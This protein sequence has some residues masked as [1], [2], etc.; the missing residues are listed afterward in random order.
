MIKRILVPLDGSELAEGVLP[1][2]ADLAKGLQAEVVF[3]QVVN[4]LSPIQ[5]MEPIS[6]PAVMPLLSLPEDV[7]AERKAAEDYLSRVVTDWR[8]MGINACCEVVLDAPASSIVGYARS[9]QVDLIAMSTHGRSGL[10]RLVFGS[11]AEQVVRE[12]GIPV[13][14][15]KP[16][17]QGRDSPPRPDVRA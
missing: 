17:Q 16:G 8:A 3:I 4:V 5:P 7:E 14:L 2:A 13:L 6:G 1:H 10:S 15:V 11:V 12:A 9:H